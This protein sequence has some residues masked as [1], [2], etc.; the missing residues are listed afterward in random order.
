VTAERMFLAVALDDES[1]HAIAAHLEA[2]LGGSRLPGRPLRPPAWHLTLR[3]LGSTTSR[4]RDRVL[5]RLDETMPVMPF[6]IKFG[7]LGAFVREERA[8]VLWLGVDHGAGGLTRLAEASEAAAVVAG[9]EP[10]GRPFHPHLTLSRIRPP[11]DVRETIDLVP[12]FGVALEVNE[13]TLYR[14]IL[15]EGPAR[16]EVVDVVE[17]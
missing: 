6:R 16:Y 1:R 13:I 11:R 17:L 2:S 9:F 3:F 14:S 4:Q 7:D 12:R 8:S 5:A 10:E 15:G